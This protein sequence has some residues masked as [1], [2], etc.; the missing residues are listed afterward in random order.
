ME[1]EME[2][3]EHFVLGESAE[4]VARRSDRETFARDLRRGLQRGILPDALVCL[5]PDEMDELGI[6]LVE[7]RGRRSAAIEALDRRFNGE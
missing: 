2:Y 7:A 5:R 6:A 3:G 4:H 1:F